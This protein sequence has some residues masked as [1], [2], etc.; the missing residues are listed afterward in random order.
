[1]AAGEGLEPSQTESESA[2]L[3]LHN[4][5]ILIFVVLKE[6]NNYTILFPFCQVLLRI[7]ILNFLQQKKSQALR[8]GIYGCGR[9][10]RTLTNRVRVCRATITQSRN[11]LTAIFHRLQSACI[12]YLIFPHLSILFLHFFHLIYKFYFSFILRQFTNKFI[13][14]FLK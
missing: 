9:R 6:L 7:N 11:T 8:L 14:T 12:L 5:A 4:P 2:V 1:M 3:P 13:P 10:A